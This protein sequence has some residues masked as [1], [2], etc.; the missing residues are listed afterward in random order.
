[1]L[2]LYRAERG[3]NERGACVFGRGA[4]TCAHHCSFSLEKSLESAMAW[5]SH[6]TASSQSRTANL[7]R[8]PAGKDGESG[9]APRDATQNDGLRRH[10][11]EDSWPVSVVCILFVHP[12]EA[13]INSNAERDAR[14]DDDDDDDDTRG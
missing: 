7:E 2:Q 10:P 6:F 14:D 5:P 13:Q 3:A 1:M 11:K 4:V 12:E 8:R 9:E